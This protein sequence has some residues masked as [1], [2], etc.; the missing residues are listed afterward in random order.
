M[1]ASAE[2][3]GTGTGTA[4]P[5]VP[6]IKYAACSAERVFLPGGG[7][8]VPLNSGSCMVP[9]VCLRLITQKAIQ[10]VQAASIVATE[11]KKASEAI[12]TKWRMQ[13]RLC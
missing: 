2:V 7:V 5:T 11:C 9:V 13:L 6:G 3:T 10:A 8:P 12:G 4:D 1:Q